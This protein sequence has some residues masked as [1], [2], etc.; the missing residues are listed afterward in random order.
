MATLKAGSRWFSTVCETELVVVRGSS[1]E[2][3]LECGGQ[4]M[5][6]F[7]SATPRNVSYLAKSDQGTQVGKRYV[8]T[9][10][11]FELLCTRPGVGLPTLDGD[12]LQ[13][14]H[15]KMLPSSD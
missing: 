14:K 15:A 11:E 13:V 6:E 9:E 12:V 5:A 2:V 4:P 7:G 1:R 8:D 10:E 3:S